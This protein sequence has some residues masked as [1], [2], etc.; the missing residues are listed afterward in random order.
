[1]DL[2]GELRTI[3]R[4][5]SIAQAGHSCTCCTAGYHWQLHYYFGLSWVFSKRAAHVTMFSSK[6]TLLD[7]SKTPVLCLGWHTAAPKSVV[8]CDLDYSGRSSGP[9]G[10]TVPQSVQT[11][12]SQTVEI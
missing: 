3:G 11:G 8:V 10:L 9:A 4:L 2:E 1:M 12:G 6:F 5:E 7:S